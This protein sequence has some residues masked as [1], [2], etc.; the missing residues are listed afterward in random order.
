V[1]SVIKDKQT[2][3]FLLLILVIGVG[4]QIILYKIAL[5]ALLLQWLIGNDFKHKFTKL[6]QNNF[7][8][9]SIVLYFLYS[10]SFF[11]SDNNELAVTDIILKS[12]LLILPL[13]L[14]SQ[15]S[16]SVKQLNLVFLSFALS[17]I[18]LN[19]YSLFESYLGY[20]DT[21]NINKFYYSNLTRNMHTSAQSMFTCF[22]IVLFTYLFI[23]ERFISNWI[24]YSTVVIQMIFVFLLSSRMQILIM[25]VIV[26]VYLISYYYKR[27]K[28]FLG[29][30]YTLIIFGFSY[31]I[32]STPSILNSR[33]NKTVS[34]INSIGVDNGN[35]D[36]RKFIWSQGLE[37][38]KNHWLVGTGVGDINDVLVSR[39]SKLILDNPTADDLVDSTIVEIQKD[40]KIVSFLKQSSI[41]SNNTY[42]NE[43][44]DYAKNTLERRNNQ[45][46]Q[47]RKR[48]YNL[49]NQYLQTFAEIGVFGFLLLGFLLVYPFI[50]SI[51]NKDYLAISF[52]FI[53][54]ASFLTE[55]ILERQAGVA[56]CALFYA[57]LVGRIN[58]NKSS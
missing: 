24:T 20:L 48:E 12:P 52:L 58:Q 4:L 53:L 56:F 39:Y 42:E 35:S 27:N 50:L 3:F 55:S 38:I 1:L 46:K 28:I 29:L 15:K 36:P 51:K 25:I 16:L 2:Y 32:I 37:V 10:I 30:L 9:A 21:N 49:H 40:N 45:F 43:V 8:L 54:G 41:N 44:S 33:Y 18:F 23:K 19:L 47:A 17:S 31:L 22:S 5:I 13:I 14:L 11:W 6:K 26:P 7:A 57:L 34:Q